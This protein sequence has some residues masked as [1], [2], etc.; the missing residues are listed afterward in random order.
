MRAR[1]QDDVYRFSQLHELRHM[2]FES[3]QSRGK[4]WYREDQQNALNGAWDRAR[5]FASKLDGWLLVQGEYGCGKTHLAAAIGNF[6]SDLGVPT[7]FITVPDLLDTLRFA[8]HANAGAFEERF[9]TVRRSP[10]LVLDDFGTQNATEWAQEKLFQILN[11]RHVN[12]LP[13][14]ITTNLALE[15]IEGRIR[16]RLIDSE[17][18]HKVGIRA[19]DY[20]RPADETG[21]N[22]LSSLALHEGQTFETFDLRRHER[23]SPGDTNS[24]ERAVKTAQQYAHAPTDWIV[25]LGPFGCGKT[26]LA[27]AI[28]NARVRLGH[29]ALFVVLPDLLDHLRATFN[30]SSAVSYDRRFEEIRAAPLLVLDD[31]GTQNMTPWVREKLY[32]LFNHRYNAQLPTVITT[33]DPIEQIDPRLSSRMLDRRRCT[34]QAITAPAFRGEARPRRAARP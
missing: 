33:A 10:L 19:P 27:A 4:R 13:T 3:F 8:Y 34:L 14:V 2:T 23:L 15:Q 9:E 32:Q 21:S 20:R 28:A 18:V 11:F 1:Q 6:C 16:S 24:L 29:P 31:M 17:L 12:R 7:L 26:H 30:P 22:E 5:N 25:F